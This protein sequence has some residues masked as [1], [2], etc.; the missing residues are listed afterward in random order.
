MKKEGNKQPNSAKKQKPT[1]EI[2]IIYLIYSQYML[3][4]QVIF[5]IEKRFYFISIDS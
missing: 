4:S 3:T 5:T 2:K 1:T